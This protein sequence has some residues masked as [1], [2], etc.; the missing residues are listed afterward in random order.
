MLLLPVAGQLRN[1][2]QPFFLHGSGKLD[3]LRVAMRPTP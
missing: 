3:L 2:D 1:A